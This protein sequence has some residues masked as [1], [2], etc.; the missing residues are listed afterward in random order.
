MKYKKY[1]SPIILICN[2]KIFNKISKKNRSKKKIKVLNVNQLNKYKLN[3]N[4]INL[5]DIKLKNS[6]VNQYLNKSFELAFKLL[7]DKFSY[8]LI[9]GPINK[10][11]FLKKNFLVS[12]NIFHTNLK[13]LT[14]EC[15]SIIKNLVVPLTTHLPLKMVSKKFLKNF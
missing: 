4:N 5:I 9:N 15:L 3:N 12:L 2:K 11:S 6:N 10:S 13:F 1:K 14:L 8:K 7:K